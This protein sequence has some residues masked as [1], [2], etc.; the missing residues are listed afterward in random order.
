MVSFAILP[1]PKAPLFKDQA[2]GQ[3][4]IRQL[5]V[6]IE[7]GLLRTDFNR[8]I[9]VIRQASYV[10]LFFFLK[11]VIGRQFDFD[12]LTEDLHLDLCNFRQSDVCMRPGAKVAV[13][14]AR[15]FGKT[16]VFTT[17]ATMWELWRQPNLRCL[18]VNAAEPQAKRFFEETE[19]PFVS[20]GLLGLLD[21]SSR[22]KNEDYSKTQ[23]RMSNATVRYKEPTLSYFGVG[24]AVAG[25]HYDILQLDDLIGQQ[26]IVG[27]YQASLSM[28]EVRRWLALNTTALLV[29]REHSRCFVIGTRY[30]PADIYQDIWEDAREFHGYRHTAAKVAENGSWDIY[31]RHVV[32][33]GIATNPYIMTVEGAATMQRLH[34]LE[35][36]YNYAND[37]T[38]SL[39]NEF[40]Q[41]E[42]GKCKLGQHS[43]TK[44][45]YI[46]VFNDNKE[47]QWIP[48]SECSTCISVDWAGSERRRSTRTSRSSIALWAADDQ[49]RRYRLD[50]YVGFFNIMDVFDKIYALGEKWQGYVNVVLIEANAMQLAVAQL[51]EGQDRFRKIGLSFVRRNAVGDKMVR[52]RTN[53]GP[54]LTAGLIH[55]TD[56][57]SIEFNE[58]RL[59][60]GPGSTKLDVLD[61]SEKAISWLISPLSDDDRRNRQDKLDESSVEQYATFDEATADDHE[62][63]YFPY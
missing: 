50:Q 23:F 2:T 5:I 55:L 54:Y 51:I 24:G 31:F 13:F 37:V 63:S 33:D 48:L 29:S 18:I 17:G 41:F 59:G 39:T 4:V 62:V 7:N 58:E 3:E 35:Y 53:L 45:W 46:R 11:Y 44:E 1:H 30:G 10:S 26:D 22:L 43:E 60:F 34:P 56:T 16:K 9:E 49:N 8:L 25:G 6:D 32:E 47:E 42:P 14:L 19:A 52:I 36:A 57:T 21:P 28:E 40:G 61:E 38:V 12:F 27:E 20:S 15:G